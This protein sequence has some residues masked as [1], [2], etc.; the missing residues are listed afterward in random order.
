MNTCLTCGHEAEQGSECVS[1]HVARLER[2]GNEIAEQHDL[3]VEE[4]YASEGEF[5]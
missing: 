1:C 2:E 5:A 3:A 4:R